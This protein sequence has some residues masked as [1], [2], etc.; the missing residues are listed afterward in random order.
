MTASSSAS[1]S[2][3]S[4][5][6]TKSNLPSTFRLPDASN[7]TQEESL[8]ISERTTPISVEA[9]SE[10]T[11]TKRRN[12]RA[13]ASQKFLSWT[14][15]VGVIAIIFCAALTTNNDGT[16]ISSS[17]S[18]VGFSSSS[19]HNALLNIITPVNARAS[20]GDAEHAEKSHK[21]VCGSGDGSGCR[22]KFER[23]VSEHVRADHDTK[24]NELITSDH[25]DIVWMRKPDPEFP[26][27]TSK[28]REVP[29]F[30]CSFGRAL[31]KLKEARE[32]LEK[33]QRIRKRN[34]EV[35]DKELATLQ[36]TNKKLSDQIAEMEAR[37]K[38]VTEELEY[39]QG[40]K[41]Q[42][43]ERNKALEEMSK[44]QA[45]ASAES[46]FSVIQQQ[47]DQLFKGLSDKDEHHEQMR[48]MEREF[49]EREKQTALEA[50]K[51]VS[52]ADKEVASIRIK[53]T[54]TICSSYLV[55]FFAFEGFKSFFTKHFHF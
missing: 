8:I 11:T 17:N 46:R 1:T 48:Q 40:S 35:R 28:G 3:V 2:S 13:K 36:E 30:R 29:C 41:E 55:S 38:Q 47:M 5:P 54:I 25:P 53:N 49:Q 4:V 34:V 7:S 52:K 22:V 33:E 50:H 23:K 16:A 27:D 31:G 19:L 14:N 51:K 6:S 43:E 37:H 15:F 44:S 45:S 20:R 10:G 21:H 39:V 9:D 24:T 32:E 26:G 18:Q 12:K 42:L